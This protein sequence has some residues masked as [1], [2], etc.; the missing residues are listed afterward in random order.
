MKTI[1]T[2]GGD[3]ER[4][5]VEVAD[6]HSAEFAL[7]AKGDVTFTVKAYAESPDFA[8]ARA[9][10]MAMAALDTKSKIEARLRGQG[11]QEDKR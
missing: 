6:I 11:A 10:D 3:P 2:T 1:K 7:T 9:T 8:V 4:A 5:M